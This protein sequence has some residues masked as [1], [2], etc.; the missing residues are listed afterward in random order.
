MEL[1]ITTP[2]LLFPAISL[3]LLAYTNRYIAI[4]SLVRKLIDDYKAGTFD[5]KKLVMQISNL[6]KRLNYI[7]YMQGFGVF[8]F[9]LCIMSM[10]SVYNAWSYLANLLFAVSLIAL[11]ISIL[12]S[13][14]EI[15]KSTTA[16]EI[17]LSEIEGLDNE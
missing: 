4:A 5:R 2:A 15:F 10:Y 13:M 7:R 6:R 11:L 8:S 9:L 17:M 3:L 12:F 1:S 16:L 14:I